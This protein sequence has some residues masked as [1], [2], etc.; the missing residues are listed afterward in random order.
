MIRTTPYSV[1]PHRK[2]WYDI[3]VM[4]IELRRDTAT[5]P[6]KEMRERAF[7]APL[8]DSVYGEDPDQAALEEEGAA[9]LGKEA[10]LYV[11]SGTMGNLIALLAQTERGDEIILEES[12]HIRT[13]ETGGAACV[14]GLMLK[15]IPGLEGYPDPNQVQAAIKKPDIHHPNITLICLESTHYRYGG[16]VPP[17]EGMAAVRDI[18]VEKGIPVHLDGARLFHSAI[19]LEVEASELAAFADTV[20]ISLSKALSAPV[21]AL[22][23]GPR[24][25]IEKADRYRKMLGGGMRQT[26]WLC[27]CGRTALTEENI[28]RLKKDHANARRLGIGLNALPLFSVDLEKT[29]TNFVLARLSKGKTVTNEADAKTVS[30]AFGKR[31]ILVTPASSD[32][33]RF[34]FSREVNEEMTE[35]VIEAAVEISEEFV[36]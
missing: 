19:Y 5:R 14:G 20:M 11:P 13:S 32:T 18:A 25:V 27:A 1:A 30:S 15:S 12:A 31:G 7:E 34:V 17:L 29:Q 28:E 26:G 4:A 24:T 10:A 22:L 21:G 36:P 23:A 2:S 8:G 3:R 33:L 35:R 16:I 9:L 6:T